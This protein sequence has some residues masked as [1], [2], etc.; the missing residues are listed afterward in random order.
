MTR[1]PRGGKLVRE[2]EETGKSTDFQRTVGKKGAWEKNR[3]NITELKG[4]KT[5]YHFIF[6]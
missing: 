1:I 5:E 3:T 6:Q 2:G 4:G